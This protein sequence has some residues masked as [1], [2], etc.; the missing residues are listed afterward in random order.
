M[1]IHRDIK[2]ENILIKGTNVILSD[3]GCCSTFDNAQARSCGTLEYAA[4]EVISGSSKIGPQVDM[5]SLGVLLY[6][7]F[8]RCSPFRGQ[9]EKQTANNILSCVISA[10]P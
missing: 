10:F 4:P 2:P 5:W 9:S 6:E 8:A 7:L 3:F 1:Y